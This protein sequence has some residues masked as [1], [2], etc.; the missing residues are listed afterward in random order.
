MDGSSHTQT[1][2][3]GGRR[4]KYV[5][6]LFIGD[7][8]AD[9]AYNC[10]RYYH[11]RMAITFTESAGKHGFSKGDAL[12]AME[13]PLYHQPGFQPPIVPGSVTHL[14]IGPARSGLT[15]EVLVSYRP[16]VSA[17]IFHVMELD[18]RRRYLIEED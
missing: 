4:R 3:R 5:G 15:I 17:T 18:H 11:I 16:P 13:A 12:H 9:L 7:G 2:L 14:F 6:S 1:P 8:Y 10:I